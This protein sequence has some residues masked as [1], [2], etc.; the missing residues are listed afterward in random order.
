MSR[1]EKKEKF[2]TEDKR[3]QLQ[4]KNFMQKEYI[5][6]IIDNQMVVVMGPAGTGKTYISAT[7]AAQEYYDG[8]IDKIILTRPNISP[9]ESLGFFPG[10]LEEKMAPWVA[11]FTD[12]IRKQLGD[13]AYETMLKNGN[14]EIAPFETMRGRSFE[15]AYVILDEAQNT[16]AKEMEM[17]VTRI[18]ENSRVIVNG[19]VMQSDIHGDSG[20]KTIIRLIGKY[21]MPVP[22]IEFQVNDIVR[23]KLCKM[24]IE[25]FINES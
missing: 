21:Q 14:L 9:S 4:P 18:G 19:D 23:S 12:V 6:A 25:A 11:P 7:I 3:P 24:W 17:F 8:R 13:G 15:D 22:I 16:T 10:T 5:R 2:K 1:R 20:L